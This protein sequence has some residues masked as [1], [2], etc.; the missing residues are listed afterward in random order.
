VCECVC[1]LV[2][3]C[4]CACACVCVCVCVRV[5]VCVCVCVSLCVYACRGSWLEAALLYRWEVRSVTSILE[6]RKDPPCRIK[7]GK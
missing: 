2:C 6:A 7:L 3:V 1:V 4:V 5:C